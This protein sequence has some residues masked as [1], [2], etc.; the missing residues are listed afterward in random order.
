MYDSDYFHA[1][2]YQTVYT[3]SIIEHI[4]EYQEDGDS[5]YSKINIDE[6]KEEILDK[7]LW[8]FKYDW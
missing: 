8:S 5:Q 6:V 7:F 2:R 1:D 4:E 3:T